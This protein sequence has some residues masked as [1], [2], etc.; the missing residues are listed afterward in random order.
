MKTHTLLPSL[1]AA[2][3]LTIEPSFGQAKKKKPE[4]KG[5]QA[6]KQPAKPPAKKKPKTKFFGQKPITFIN[7]ALTL[8]GPTSKIGREGI[9][10]DLPATVSDKDGKA[11]IAYLAVIA[12]F[13]AFFL[14]EN[15]GSDDEKTVL[16]HA[17]GRQTGI[18]GAAGIALHGFVDGVAIGQAFHLGEAAGWTISIAILV[19][20]FTDGVTVAGVMRGT[21]QGATATRVMIGLTAMA[22][23]AG[24]WLQSMVV[25]PPL[26]VGL[27]LAWFAGV[28]LYLGTTMLPSAGAGRETRTVPLASL[29][30]VL[31]VAGISLA[32]H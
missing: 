7:T 30:G 17:H 12:G 6:A 9:Q 10:C 8:A 16:P 26:W 31:L 24:W 3:M 25:I 23:L 15:T 22:P 5:K 18:W 32:L 27:T 20:K 1:L 19:H 28:F 13:F 4:P 2:L 11:H 14:I 29:L 21:E